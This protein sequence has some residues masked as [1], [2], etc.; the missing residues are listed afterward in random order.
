[1]SNATE[2][3][4]KE[5]PAWIRP[6]WGRDTKPTR[7]SFPRGRYVYAW[8]SDTDPLPFYIGKGVDGRAWERHQ[9][10]DGRAMW[11][12][13]VR[14]TAKGFRAEVIRDNLTNE[15]AL[16]VEAV[17]IAFTQLLGALLTNQV[18]GMSRQEQPPLELEPPF[19]P[20]QAAEDRAGGPASEISE[21]C[22][23]DKT[24]P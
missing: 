17:L 7:R 13:T 20:P 19:T 3:R 10:A 4:K 16:L 14:S 8:F 21:P 18:G 12:Q 22:T 11:C 5:K 6:T 23:P 1:M 9:D 15:G 2:G 24:A